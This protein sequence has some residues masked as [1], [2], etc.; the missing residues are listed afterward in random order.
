MCSELIIPQRLSKID[1]VIFWNKMIANLLKCLSLC[2]NQCIVYLFMFLYSFCVYFPLTVTF[3]WKISFILTHCENNGTFLSL[4][5]SQSQ[6]SLIII[7]NYLCICTYKYIS[8]CL[9]IVF[10]L[11]AIHIV[12]YT[13]YKS[14]QQK[15][16]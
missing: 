4:N 15:R 1:A 12:L 10:V 9:C 6:Y 8:M 13:V 5:N 3:S 7:I 2:W 16:V 11:L 14:R